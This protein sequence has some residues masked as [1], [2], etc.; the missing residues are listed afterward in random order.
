AAIL[1]EPR[2][3]VGTGITR[4]PAGLTHKPAPCIEDVS[5]PILTA[6]TYPPPAG[7]GAIGRH[8]EPRR[9][10]AGTLDAKWIE[11]RAPMPP[12][13][14]DDRFNL[15]ATP[16]L[17][18]TPPRRGGEE[19]GLVNLQPGGGSAAFL[20]PRVGVEIEFRVKGRAPEVIRPYLDTVLVDTLANPRKE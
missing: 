14:Q 12:A 6:K 19:V 5:Q 20:L 15:C 17:V 13:A 2:N 4:D 11:Q 3:P 8:W 16:D 10:Y 1:E 9:R 7:I 18:A